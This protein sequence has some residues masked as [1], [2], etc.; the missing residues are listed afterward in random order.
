MTP[1]VIV[2]K[3]QSDKA[4]E[5]R[6]KHTVAAASCGKVALLYWHMEIAKRD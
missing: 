1:M 4:A 2:K 6:Y 5:L 3:F